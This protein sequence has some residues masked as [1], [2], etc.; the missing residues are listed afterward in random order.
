MS[1]EV[2]TR[3][4]RHAWLRYYTDA[5]VA[6]LLRR[7]EASGLDSRQLAAR[8]TL[9]AGADRI[10]GVHPLRA[11]F[12][13]RKLRHNR[14]PGSAMER[15]L[16]FHLPRDYLHYTDEAPISALKAGDMA[17]VRGI[18]LQTRLIPKRPR[19]FEALLQ[20]EA[21]TGADGGRCVLTWFNPYGLDKKLLPGMQVRV[22]GKVTVFRN[23][24]QIA[25]P[26]YEILDGKGG[27]AA[28]PKSAP[29]SEPAAG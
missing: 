4:Y 11:G 2:W 24:F 1:S 18:L 5:H 9:F 8:L 26:K 16:L 25:Q 15:G 29:K 14:R 20:D 7:A 23:R 17:T 13:R 27:E 22:T 28:A 3:V 10:E 6:R 21:S 12:L 19:R